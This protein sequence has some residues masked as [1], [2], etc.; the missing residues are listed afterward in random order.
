MVVRIDR[1]GVES[2]P[3]RVRMLAP[4]VTHFRRGELAVPQLTLSERL[5]GT[6][7]LEIAAIL[8]AAMILGALLVGNPLAAVMVAAGLIVVGVAN[9]APQATM[10][11]YLGYILVQDLIRNFI[12][13]SSWFYPVFKR[14][15]EAMLVVLLLAAAARR[16][17]LHDPVLKKAYSL[18][19]AAL[20]IGAVSTLVSA[21][22]WT[23]AVVDVFLLTKGFLVFYVVSHLPVKR[24]QLTWPL[25]LALGAG[26]VCLVA[27]VADLMFGE[28]YRLTIHHRRLVEF[29][30]GAA[31]VVSIFE[32]PGTAGWFFAFCA[33]V[34]LAY[35]VVRHRMLHLVL[36]FA[37][38]I[39]S[40]LS[41]R[42]KPLVGLLVVF[43]VALLMSSRTRNMLRT[44]TAAG[45]IIGSVLWASGDLIVGI[46]QEMFQQYVY[47][48]DPMAVARN[49]M[50][51]TSV[52]IGFDYFPLGAGFGRF[53][54][55][56]AA[57]FYSPLYYQYGLNSV[58]GLSEAQ[59]SFLQDAFWPHVIGELG[60]IGAGL[61][62]AAMVHLVMPQLRAGSAID[63]DVRIVR[64]AALFC[65]LEA[66]PESFGWVIFE[67]SLAASWI[68]GLLALATVA[69]RLPSDAPD[70]IS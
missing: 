37:F 35:W 23:L 67:N 10:L 61:F 16:T 42:R 29:R 25:S 66:I 20:C 62:V 14:G 50:L 68:F 12:S 47:A 3:P 70:R 45:L 55:W 32:H 59:P 8:G 21:D 11:T 1:C 24:S 36:C 60:F 44:V 58:Y 54:G 15:D 49:A 39:G 19:A 48:A 41:L 52:Q 63:A 9:V 65:F 5:A 30:M 4:G 34:A 69:M 18:L 31:T 51:R 17:S 22:S 27:A 56:I 57:L 33:C 28:A 40:L 64:Y 53:G 38:T 46:F 6:Q 43:V 7:I 26:C 2:A 13:E